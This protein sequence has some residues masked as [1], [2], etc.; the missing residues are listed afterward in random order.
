[1]KKE[2]DKCDCEFLKYTNPE[3]DSYECIKCK[4][5]FV[6]THKYRLIKEMNIKVREVK[7]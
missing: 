2:K 1:M 7:R 4:T 3:A 5:I 6:V